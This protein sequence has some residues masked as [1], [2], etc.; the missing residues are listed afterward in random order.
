MIL[1]AAFAG[2]FAADGRADDPSAIAAQLS[3]GAFAMLKSLNAQNSGGASSPMLGPVA[4]FAGDAQTL[5]HAL[6]N[7]DRRAASI[8]FGQLQSD[9]STV[10]AA[11]GAHPG[12]LKAA[13]WGKLKGQLDA[14]AKQIP[15]SA[16]GSESIG[17]AGTITHAPAAAES[18]TAG[19]AA[20]V[21]AAPKVVIDSRTF[22]GSDVT[23]KG[24]F[25]GT[26]LKTAGIY[27]GRRRVRAF[28]VN[29][30]LGEQ[31][32]EFD[33][34]LQNPTP[35]AAIRIVDVD[36][37]VGEASVLDPATSAGD[38]LASAAPSEP[39][40][41]EV[42]RDSRSET[43]E[44]SGG[45]SPGGNTTEIPSH[46]PIA[47]SPSKRHTHGG[48]LGNVQIQIISSA[49]INTIPPTYEVV[50]QIQGRGITHA[51]IYVG[52]RLVKKIPIEDGANSTSFEQRFP[53]NGGA[54]SIRAYGVGNQYVES[55]LDL[56][57]STGIAMAPM[58]GAPMQYPGSAVVQ[59]TSVRQIAP[60]LDVVT[61]VISGSNI[62][63]AGLYQNGMLVQNLALSKGIAGSLL[64]ALIPGVTRNVNFSARFNPN[65]GQAVVRVFDSSGAYTDQ[66]VMVAGMNPYGGYGMMN[67]Y[68]SY[69]A[70]PYGGYGANPYGGYG[71]ATSPFAPRP[72]ATSPGISP[73]FG[74][75]W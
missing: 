40:G 37:R 57:T 63:A 70:N 50:G 72:P 9:Q 30:V 2:V 64:G 41:V 46:G 42:L 60:S 22:N 47:P 5:S 1:C 12:T 43:P 68:G 10:D 18:G 33:I 3:D 34:G 73:P 20:S 29:D 53:M 6:A 38:E 45:E 65:A 75:S 27:Q 31:R 16:G 67:P 25:E 66:P 19:T 56:G 26:A 24:Y 69:G 49:Q 54:A 15:A 58:M 61:G 7:R 32:V 28:K 52:N 36:G 59:I 51:G 55:S 11:L 14:L 48:K 35:D 21:G 44:T 8:A 74:G 4:G 23:L 71:G 17:A 39:P 13:D 62:T